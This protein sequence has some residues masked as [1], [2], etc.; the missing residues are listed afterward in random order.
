MIRLRRAG[1]AAE[2]EGRRAQLSMAMNGNLRRFR[3]GLGP[4]P[5]RDGISAV[6]LPRC[7]DDERGIVRKKCQ[8]PGIKTRVRR[9]LSGTPIQPK[10]RRR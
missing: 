8:I 5:A 9:N 10:R 7:K 2:D 6:R 4:S 1:A 3:P